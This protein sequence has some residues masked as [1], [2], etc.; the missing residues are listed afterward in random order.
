MLGKMKVL[1][2]GSALFLLLT[3][4]NIGLFVSNRTLQDEVGERSQ[5]IQQSLQLEKIYQ[6][7]VRALA[8]L[9]AN[10]HDAQISNLLSSQGI[11]FTVTPTATSSSAPAATP[12]P[13]PKK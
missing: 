8:D 12:T 4:M 10:R 9:A 7:L 13:A 11:S 3:V 1:L 5:Y 6:P 2:L